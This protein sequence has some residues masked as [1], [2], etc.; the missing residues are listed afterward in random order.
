MRNT[1]SDIIKAR[2]DAT[3]DLKLLCTSPFQTKPLLPWSPDT[4]G[5]DHRRRLT[6][7]TSR[8]P[9]EAGEAGEPIKSVRREGPLGGPRW[10]CLDALDTR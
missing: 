6:S 1:Y 8:H 9:Y 4:K 7:K 3:Q 10:G 5:G 2:G